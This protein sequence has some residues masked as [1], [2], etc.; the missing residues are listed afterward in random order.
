MRA[1]IVPDPHVPLHYEPAVRCVLKAIPIVSPDT[2]VFLGDIGEWESVSPWK[3]KKK[4]R[5]PIEYI[6]P[7]IEEDA[8]NVNIFLDEF[9]KVCKKNKV[10]NKIICQGNHDVWLDYFVEE[11]PFLKEYLFKNLIN[12]NERGYESLSYG[13][14]KKI[15]KLHIYHGGHYGTIHHTRRHALHLGAN[16]LYA[17]NHDVQRSNITQVSGYHGAWSIGCLKDMSKEANS[18]LR[19]KATNWGHAFAVVDWWG[20]G[21]FRIDVV[22]ITAGRTHLWGNFIDGN[23]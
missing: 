12:A 15:G 3:W 13:K 2:I 6:L 22:D 16:V 17:H 5:P 20:R 8:K 19:G 9:D 11:N 10:K 4:R 1:I 23:K 21:H 18:W 14:R 7:Q